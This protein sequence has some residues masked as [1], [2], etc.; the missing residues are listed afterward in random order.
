MPAE[1][2]V[3]FQDG[4]ASWH[5]ERGYLTISAP[6][7]HNDGSAVIALW[8][9]DVDQLGTWL[10][11]LDMETPYFIYYR[12]GNK[13]HIVRDGDTICSHN[14][15]VLGPASDQLKPFP[16]VTDREWGSLKTANWGDLCSQCRSRADR[17]DLFPEGKRE[18]IPQFPCPVCG[19]PVSEISPMMG[20]GYAE[21]DDGPDHEFNMS[22]FHEWRKGGKIETADE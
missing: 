18:E 3:Q 4:Y 2:S 20:I 19:E 12:Q 8:P 6:S 21:H 14:V 16:Q 5:P 17:G 15:N 1:R 10:A 11:D 7:A 9:S 13:D 22:V